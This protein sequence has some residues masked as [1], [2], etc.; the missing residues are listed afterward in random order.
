MQAWKSLD[1]PNLVVL[2]TF[3]KKI[4][5]RNQYFS[6]NQ[7]STFWIIFEQPQ[8]RPIFQELPWLH[9]PDVLRFHRARGLRRGSLAWAFPRR[10]RWVGWGRAD[11]V[12]LIREK[13]FH[14]SAQKCFPKLEEAKPLYQRRWPWNLDSV[15]WYMFIFNR[16]IV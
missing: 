1:R 11:R 10:E 16:I 14:L 6:I 5:E 3:R 15:D 7:I 9:H 13:C 4:Q 2:K 12:T 8:Q